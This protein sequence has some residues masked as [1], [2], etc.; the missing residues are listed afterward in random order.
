MAW[1][2]LPLCRTVPSGTV[3][4]KVA[5]VMGLSAIRDQSWSLRGGE[6]E[7]PPPDLQP[8]ELLSTAGLQKPRPELQ[9]TKDN[10]TGETQHRLPTKLGQNRGHKALV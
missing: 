8:W 9:H 3:P 1:S 2:W 10:G 4:W 6:A 7:L 5:L